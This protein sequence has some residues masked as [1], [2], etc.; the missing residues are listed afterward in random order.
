MHTGEM[1]E[2]TVRP[3]EEGYTFV[4]DGVRVP[5]LYE[6]VCDTTRNTSL[7]AG[8]V[9]IMTVEHLLS[10][11]YGLRV[12]GAEI[13]VSGPEVP[14]LDGSALEFATAIYEE[15]EEA[16]GHRY[17]LKLPVEYS[18]GGAEI[19]GMPY[20]GLRVSYAIEYSSPV[21]YSAFIDVEITPET[22]L[23]EIAPARTFAFEEEVKD[24]IAK[25]LARGGSLNNALIL[26]EDGP[27]NERVPDEAVRHKVLDFLGD[28]ALTGK[29]IDGHYVVF[30]G[31]HSAHTSFARKLYEEG[32]WGRGMDVKEILSL[33][34]HRYPF[35][36]VDRIIHMD[37]RRIVGVKNVTFNEDFFNGHFPEDP[38]MPG[39]LQVEALAQVAGVGLAHKLREMGKGDVLP[40]FAGIE[41]VRFRRVV[42]PGD[43]L[44]LE[45]TLLRFGGRLAKARGRAFVDGDLTAEAVMIATFV[46]R[47][48]T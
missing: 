20:D 38:I 19:R 44:I 1:A 43:T 4:K 45:A 11:L 10:A 42:R 37:D 34:P 41:N 18:E 6:N 24:L 46:P 16:E 7:C 35:L 13:E 40:L 28:L 39:V 14:A 36:L 26:T 27:K 21:R 47:G 25:G 23:K 15:S 2:V 17:V 5:A 32:I 48:G 9:R 29:R 22:Y 33:L 31:G 30:R 3:A 8:E 12:V